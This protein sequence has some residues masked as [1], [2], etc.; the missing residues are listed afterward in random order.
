MINIFCCF[1]SY[2]FFCCFFSKMFLLLFFFTNLFVVVIFS[3]SRNCSSTRQHGSGGHDPRARTCTHTQRSHMRKSHTRTHW[4]TTGNTCIFSNGGVVGVFEIYHNTLFQHDVLVR[5]ESFHTP[6]LGNIFCLFFFY[7]LQ[8]TSLKTQTC[9][10]PTPTPTPTPSSTPTHTQSHSYANSNSNSNRKIQVY[11]GVLRS[12]GRAV[13]VKVQRPG[14]AQEVTKDLYV[15]KRA[16]GVYQN[17][18]ER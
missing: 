13:A 10:A 6:E 14:L 18:S 8:K 5:S 15:L 4:Y 12:D 11:R 3:R 7:R 1:F 17:L 2:P 9:S 16:V